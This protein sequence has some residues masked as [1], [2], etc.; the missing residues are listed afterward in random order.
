MRG[1]GV[2]NGEIVEFDMPEYTDD[3]YGPEICEDDR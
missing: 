3:D 1:I 2:L